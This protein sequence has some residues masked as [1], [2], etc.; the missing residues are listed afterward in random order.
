VISTRLTIHRRP[1]SEPLS[2][3]NLSTRTQ[4]L[5]L[6]ADKRV[7]EGVHVGGDERST[8]VSRETKLG[9]VGEGVWGE[10][11]EEKGDEFSCVFFFSLSYTF[12][13]LSFSLFPC[14]LPPLSSASFFFSLFSLLSSLFSPLSLSLSLSYL[15]Q[16]CASTNLATS[17]SGMPIERIMFH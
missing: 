2:K 13:F 7:V 12:L 9:Q 5:K 11:P 8:E 6:P 16:Y 3:H 15:S 10:V 4:L 1:D 14:S 17:F